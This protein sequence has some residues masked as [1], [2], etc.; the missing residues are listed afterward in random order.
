[1]AYDGLAWWMGGLCSGSNQTIQQDIMHMCHRT[2]GA[3]PLQ[4]LAKHAKT[5]GWEG[6]GGG[7]TSDDNDGEERG[8][9]DIKKGDEGRHR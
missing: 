5:P 1:M 7:G 4:R 6:S 3:L 2:W 8:G 9:G